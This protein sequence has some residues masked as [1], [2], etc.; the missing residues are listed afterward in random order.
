MWIGSDANVS[1]F[2]V[3]PQALLTM[4]DTITLIEGE[5]LKLSVNC[6]GSQNIYIWL[7]DGEVIDGAESDS[8]VILSTLKGDSGEYQCMVQ[9]P[10]VPG[11]DLASDTFLVVVNYPV[12]ADL[13]EQSSFRINGNPVKDLLSIDSDNSVDNLVIMDIAGRI[14][15]N[16]DIN[17]STI[18]VN[19]SDLKTG[20]YFVSLKSGQSKRTLK[21]I[22]E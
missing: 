7:K 19:V 14:L 3:S 4:K 11:L 21:I 6:G 8:L 20:I 12:S 1:T 15:R 10:L 5:L 13:V 16:M 17:S 18:R 9:S 2:E 22:K